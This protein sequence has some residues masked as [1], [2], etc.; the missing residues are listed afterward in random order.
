MW[1]TSLTTVQVVIG[2]FCLTN[3]PNLKKIPYFLLH[4]TEKKLQILTVEKLES[5]SFRIRIFAW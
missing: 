5:E 4:K 3:S 2:L 1:K